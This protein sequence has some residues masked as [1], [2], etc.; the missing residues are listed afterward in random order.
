MLLRPALAAEALSELAVRS[1]GH[2]GYD[3]AFLEACRQE[4]KLDPDEVTRR[5]ITVAD[6]DGIAAGFYSL[7]GDP[8]Q[9]ELGYLFVE[10]AWI[11]RGV[12]RRL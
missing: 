2:W 9:G 4:L 7:D 10:P 3:A 6:K 11:G 1:K 12:G 8:P 5:R